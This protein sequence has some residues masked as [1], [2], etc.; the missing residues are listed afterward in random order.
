MRKPNYTIE[1][2]QEEALKYNS[3]GQTFIILTYFVLLMISDN[4]RLNIIKYKGT[5]A[6]LAVDGI[7]PKGKLPTKEK[8]IQ[9]AQKE[10]SNWLKEIEIT[11]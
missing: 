9:D 2:C 8:L 3:R 10:L 7:V 1:S 4:N 5:L 6:D 11:V